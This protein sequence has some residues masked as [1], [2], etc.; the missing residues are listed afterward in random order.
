MQ[1]NIQYFVSSILLYLHSN[2]EFFDI[3]GGKSYSK[4]EIS[5]CNGQPVKGC[6]VQKSPMHT[7]NHPAC[8]SVNVEADSCKSSKALNFKHES[9][10]YL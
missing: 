1:Q 5:G 10:Y 4:F 3:P 8:F 2:N 7:F 9:S 6:L